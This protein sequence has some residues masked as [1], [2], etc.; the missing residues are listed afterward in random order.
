MIDPSGFT[1][2]SL[3]IESLTLSTGRDA[4]NPA[5][6][7]RSER[8]HSRFVGCALHAGRITQ[9]SW[10]F[11]HFV[12]HRFRLHQPAFTRSGS[13]RRKLQESQ[14]FRKRRII[15]EQLHAGKRRP[16]KI[17]WIL[18]ALPEQEVRHLLLLR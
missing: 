12:V 14:R 4:G 8:R 3:P 16:E 7:S 5:R 9:A 18:I 11:L 15:L 6:D 2:G 1:A 13:L 17:V 10:S